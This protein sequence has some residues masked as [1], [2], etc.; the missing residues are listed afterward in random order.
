MSFDKNNKNYDRIAQ[1]AR[2]ETLNGESFVS[3]N[4]NHFSIPLAAT[5]R[6]NYNDLFSHVA[7]ATEAGKHIIDFN[8]NKFSE[9]GMYVE[10][11]FADIFTLKM[12]EG[13]T[14]D[15]SNPN[16]ILLSKSAANVLFG[17]TDAVGKVIKLDSDQ[18]LKA[19]AYLKT[20]RTIIAFHKLQHPASINFFCLAIGVT[21]SLLIGMYVFNQYKISQWLKNVNSQYILKSD[22]K[23]KEMRLDLTTY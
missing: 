2:K 18:P 8:G 17:K 1:I 11:N 22:W 19:S 20:C 6:T 14:T 16:S 7:L 15:F 23:V 12:I 9:Q 21:S 13:T 3:E 10:K 5:L 4:S